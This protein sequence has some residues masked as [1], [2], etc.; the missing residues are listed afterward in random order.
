M[1]QTLNLSSTEPFNIYGENFHLFEKLQIWIYA[2]ESSSEAQRRLSNGSSKSAS[3]PEEQRK[4][5]GTDYCVPLCEHISRENSSHL[6]CHPYKHFAAAS[7]PGTYSL[8]MQLQIGDGFSQ[9]PAE[10]LM[11][12]QEPE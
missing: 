12:L 3:C 10:S 2:G 8:K 6:K 7:L 1:G 5:L 4:K 11:K 9:P